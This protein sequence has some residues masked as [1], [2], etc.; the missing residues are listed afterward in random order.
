MERVTFLVERTGERI[1]CL[2]NPEWLEVRRAAG[3]SRRKRVGGAIIGNPRTDDPLVATGG[4][5][6]DYELKLLFDVDLIVQTSATP[7]AAFSTPAALSPEADGPLGLSTSLAEGAV[8]EGAEAIIPPPP[9]PTSVDVRSLTQPLWALAEN[10]DPV[11]GNIAPQ[12]VRFIWGRSWNVPGVVLAA[13]ER[14]E[15]FDPEG[16]P[17]RSWLNLL[18]RRV[19]EEA[20]PGSSPAP[21]TSPQF[22][23]N[24]ASTPT[25]D[26]G[27]DGIVV[28]V[29]DEGLALTPLHMIAAERYG[30][31]RYDRAIAE[32]N[33]L[34]DLLQLDEGRTI[35][36][37]PVALAAES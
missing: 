30:D 27:D 10:G 23:I 7:F 29:D 21:P 25:D 18:L 9:P 17:Q 33:D 5:T 26:S 8:S 16:I 19:E 20:D 35:R 32:Y 34:D 31:P 22:E 2:L 3:I 6:T 36:L 4:G 15:R 11:N 12:R 14:L 24:P 13:A 1:P 37:P 28:P